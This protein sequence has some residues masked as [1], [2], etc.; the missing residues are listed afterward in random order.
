MVVVIENDGAQ[1]A[2]IAVAATI[3]LLVLK[4][5]RSLDRVHIGLALLKK[6]H[7]LPCRGTLGRGERF[8]E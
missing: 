8:N 7:T 4:K 5:P 2:G 6:I 1:A 3:Q